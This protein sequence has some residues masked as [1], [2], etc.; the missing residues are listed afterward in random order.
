MDDPDLCDLCK[1]KP[2]R[3]LLNKWFLVS[4]ILWRG[5]SMIVRI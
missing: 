2:K 3:L 1:Y 4:T 5:K